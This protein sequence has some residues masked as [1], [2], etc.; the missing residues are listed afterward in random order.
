[1]TALTRL[2]LERVNIMAILSRFSSVWACF[3]LAHFVAGDRYPDCV[4]GPLRN[5]SVCRMDLDPAERAA[6]LVAAMTIEE[7]L[8]NLVE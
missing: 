4:S 6:A 5:N 2:Q 3:A 1:L 8:V 7:K